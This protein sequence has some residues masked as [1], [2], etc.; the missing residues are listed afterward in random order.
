MAH[1][2]V[3]SSLS[4][5][6]L[7]L[8]FGHF[9]LHCRGGFREPYW[10]EK[11]AGHDQ[12]E[13]YLRDRHTLFSLCLVSRRMRDVAQHVLHHEFILGYA[14]LRRRMAYSWRGR[15]T[16][17]IRTVSTRRDLAALVKTVFFHPSLQEGVELAAAWVAMRHAADALQ[18]DLTEVWKRR[19]LDDRERASDMDHILL[20]RDLFLGPL[21]SIDRVTRFQDRVVLVPE[22]LAVLLA[23]LP[24]LKQLVFRI[25]VGSVDVPPAAMSALGV[26]RLPLR[27][28]ETSAGQRNLLGLA[29]DLESLTCGRVSGFEKFSFPR[30]KSFCTRGTFVTNKD[31]SRTVESCPECLSSFTYETSGGWESGTRVMPPSEAVAQLS[32]FR[33]TLKSLHIDLRSGFLVP[34]DFRLD[35]FP[36]LEGFTVLESLFL[37]TNAIYHANNLEPP[38]EDSLVAI[39]PPSIVSLTLAKAM[40][41]TPKRLM[42]G[43][44]GLAEYKRCNPERFWKLKFVRCDTKEVCFDSSVRKA[45]GEV[46]V[47]LV[48]EQF[49]R[50]DLR[51]YDRDG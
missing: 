43:L 35:I 28:L 15:L 25:W 21:H 42:R 45:F 24:N 39:L 13:A 44:L 10:V 7:H 18:V 23:L 14:H 49:P 32:K 12:S 2:P 33:G 3:L 41:S 31:F 9:C 1:A 16:S 6:L 36:N 11:D 47:D 19:R 38:D 46:D 51:N 40:P 50:Q 5:E 26:T 8:I 30:L 48:Y 20:R 37:T 4:T 29:P 34:Q 27:I 17:F 22:L